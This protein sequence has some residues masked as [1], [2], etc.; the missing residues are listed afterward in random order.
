[1]EGLSQSQAT[2]VREILRQSLEAAGNEAAANLQQ[3]HGEME[4]LTVQLGVQQ[5]EIAVQV[6]KA[7]TEKDT[8]K[9]VMERFH[10]E[11]EAMKEIMATKDQQF[12]AMKENLDQM[13]NAKVQIVAEVEAKTTLIEGLVVQLRDVTGQ[14]LDTIRQS[15]GGFEDT[16]NNKL[17]QTNNQ[18]LANQDLMAQ[19]FGKIENQ[20]TTAEGIL[21]TLGER[22]SMVEGRGAHGGGGTNP[23]YGGGGSGGGDARE[24]SLISIKDVRL[25]NLTENNPTVAVFRKWW[26]ELA[27]YC[28]KREAHWRGAETLFK[29]I[30]SYPN[31]IGPKEY[32]EFMM[33]CTNRDKTTTG[34]NYDFGEWEVYIRAR[35]LFDCVEYA[36]NGKCG[37]IVSSVIPGDGFELLRKL[38]RKFDPL[39][40]QAASVYKGRVFATAGQPCTSFVKTVERLQELER[41]RNEMR[42]NTGE[43][44]NNETLA[45][46]FF[47]TMDASCQSEI[48]ALRIKIGTG[49]AAR[50]INGS[51]F[52]DLAEY[53][54]DRIHRERTLVPVTASKMDVSGVD[55]GME[56]AAAQ[57]A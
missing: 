9:S 41:L 13:K 38:A 10:A 57:S 29:V 33:T 53:V 31:E 2:A 12:A 55:I 43:D 26:K 1:M 21:R 20:M 40:P 32:P 35:E 17:D 27:K 18:V 56:S 23:G 4:A 19:N 6:Q 36:L 46:V 7:E 22:I 51:K 16:I 52:E 30:R 48:V 5:Q 39:S 24:K 28:Q 54:R 45:E 49:N 47:P 25:P 42:E 11:A 3:K 34:T 37:D 14:A 50:E 15:Y 8:M 44:M